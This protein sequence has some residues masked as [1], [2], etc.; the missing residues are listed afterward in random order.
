MDSKIPDYAIGDV[1]VLQIS[2]ANGTKVTW[3]LLDAMIKHAGPALLG[4]VVSV[5][6]GV[7]ESVYDSL[8][9]GDLVAFEFTKAIELGNGLVAVRGES[10]LAAHLTN[11]QVKEREAA[12]S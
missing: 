9:V 2:E 6:G 10:V 1:V 5:G 11:V 3:P 7:H 8:E 12:L 4:E